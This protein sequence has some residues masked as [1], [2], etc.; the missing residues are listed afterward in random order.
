MKR[1]HVLLACVALGSFGLS[2]YA[3]DK[4]PNRPADRPAQPADGAQP[5]RGGGQ[6]GPGGG[7]QLSAEKSKAAW[8]A[9]AASVAKRLGYNEEQTKAVTKAYTEA[10]ESFNTASA[11]AR[12]EAMQKMREEREKNK[13]NKDNQDGAGRRGAGLGDMAKAMEEVTK[14]E[15][16]KFE[17][18]LPG[19]LSGDQRT[20]TIASLGAFNRQWDTLTDTILGMKLE[21]EKQQAAME[22][23]EDY[24]AAVAKLRPTAGGGA[25]GPPSEADRE[26]M[27]TE[28]ESARKK[29][30]ESLKKSLTDEQLKKIEDATNR[31]RGGPGGGGRGGPGGPGGGAGGGDNGG[32]GQPAPRRRGGGGGGGGGF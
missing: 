10:R 24:S 27:R 8:E 17:K 20:K 3:Q 7:G 21:A 4:A 13:D 9:Q 30:T 28:M 5:R 29:L 26:K 16:E 11:K 14:A 1:I 18:A 25:G 19:S 6:G 32:D 22:A 12:D 23:I 2:A 31:G 15:K